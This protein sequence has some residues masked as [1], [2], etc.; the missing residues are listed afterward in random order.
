MFS[1]IGNYNSN[2]LDFDV[3]SDWHLPL[4]DTKTNDCVE[5]VKVH[6]KSEYL[7]LLGD[8]FD[9]DQGQDSSNHINDL[10]AKLIRVYD[11]IFFVPGNHDL[12]G[13]D[14]PWSSFSFSSSVFMPSQFAP[15]VVELSRGKKIL[16]GNIF[17]DLDF[18]DPALIGIDLEAARTFYEQETTD[19]RYLLGGN[20]ASFLEMTQAVKNKLSTQID[21]VAT[22]AVPHPSLVTFRIEKTN[23]KLEA[24]AQECGIPFIVDLEDDAAQAVRYKTTPELAR[25]YW[26]YK[27]IV[28]GSNIFKDPETLSFKDGLV[29][30]YGHNHRPGDRVSKLGERSVR[31]ISHQPCAWK[32][33]YNWK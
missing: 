22:H 32:Y 27:S 28:M 9:T 16:L 29:A 3:G 25:R 31:F 8:I 11:L 7:F 2:G 4:D 13:R 17:Y 19:G 20:S 24:L 6:Q 1:Y 18:V 14:L 26:N 23:P 33:N 15:K 30:L 10:L 21:I 12:R 5:N